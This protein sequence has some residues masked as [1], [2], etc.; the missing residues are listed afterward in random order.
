MMN[1]ENAEPKAP[2]DRLVMRLSSGSEM[3]KTT[4]YDWVWLVV[5]L[6]SGVLSSISEWHWSSLVFG[7]CAGNQMQICLAGNW[8]HAVRR[9]HRVNREMAID[10]FE[11]NI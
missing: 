8:W 4:K 10:A 9:L 7:F 3:W 11:R 1:S 6:L 2:V 5:M